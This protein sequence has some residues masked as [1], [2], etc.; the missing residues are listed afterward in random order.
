MGMLVTAT[1]YMDGLDQIKKNPNEFVE[2]LS[3]IAESGKSDYFGLGN[4][5]NVVNVQK[6]RHSDDRTIYVN[7]G[8]TVTEVNP[9]DDDFLTLMDKFPDFTDNLIYHLNE[10]VKKIKDIQKEKAKIVKKPL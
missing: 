3:E 6:C 2:K 8:N 7:M 1:I 4:H 10:T 9:Y 5:G